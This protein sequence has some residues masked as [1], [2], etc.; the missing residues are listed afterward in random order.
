M[1]R[2][3]ILGLCAAV[4]LLGPPTA[5]VAQI[6]GAPWTTLRPTAPLPPQTESGRVDVGDVEL[7]YAIY[8][9]GRPVVL[10][11][12]G[13]GHSDYWANQIGPLSQEFQVVVVDL[14]GHGRSGASGRELDGPTVATILVRR[15]RRYFESAIRTPDAGPA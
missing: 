12:P 14:R 13:L 1:S 3:R 7:Y 4:L 9:K 11:H 2:L 10:L 5:A 6:A 15:R 8:G